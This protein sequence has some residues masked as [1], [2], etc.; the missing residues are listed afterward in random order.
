[1]KDVGRQRAPLWDSNSS[2]KPKEETKGRNIT[3][4]IPTVFDLLP[5]SPEAAQDTGTLLFSLE[6]DAFTGLKAPVRYE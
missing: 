1:M 3:H 4:H 2:W 5:L 6:G